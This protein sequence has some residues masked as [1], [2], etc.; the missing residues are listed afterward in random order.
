MSGNETAVRDIPNIQFSHTPFVYGD[1]WNELSSASGLWSL[2]SQSVPLYSGWLAPE[3][4]ALHCDPNTNTHPDPFFRWGGNTSV[5]G[6]M[7][8]LSLMRCG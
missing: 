8:Y 3:S 5:V 2:P 6:V 1:G 4:L 7:V